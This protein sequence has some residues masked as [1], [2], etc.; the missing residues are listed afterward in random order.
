MYFTKGVWSGNWGVTYE[1]QCAL[2][3]TTVDL[4]CEYDYSLGSIVTWA[5]WSKGQRVSNKLSLVPLSAIPSPPNHFTYLGNYRGNCNLRINNVQPSDQGEFYFSFSTTLGSWREVSSYAALYVKE[6]TSV[7]QPSTAREGDTVRLICRSGCPDP[8]EVAWF[9][10]GQRVWSTVFQARRE[11]A[12]RYLCVTLGKERVWSASVALIVHYAPT[13]VT[14]SANPSGDIDRGST[15]TL[16]CSSKANPPVAQG[17]YRL[18][19]DGEYVSSGQTRV[20]SDVQPRH[21]GRYHCRAWNSLSWRGSDLI[22]SSEIHLNVQYHPV[23]VSVSVNAEPIVEGSSVNLTCSSDAN[24]AADS[25][26]WYKRT[27][28]SSSNSLLHV[29]SGQVLSIPSMESS[30]SGLYVCHVRNSRGEGNSTEVVLAMAAEQRGSQLLPILAGV[31]LFLVALLVAAL[32]LFRKKEKNSAEKNQTDLD[33]RLNGGTSNSEEATA[34]IYSNIHILPPCPDPYNTPATKKNTRRS[35]EAEIIYSTVTIK[36]SVQ[37]KTRHK[38]S[39]SKGREDD[40][41]V[42][43]S[44]VV[45]SS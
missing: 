15:V 45:K 13:D 27:E 20:I 31:G 5:G 4:K 8:T 3:G 22:N 36:P 2:I 21:T 10:D 41:S 11:D 23:N 7:V 44:S 39:W 28:T 17:G 29:G 35:S 32:L 37:N 16:T 34:A 14:L 26:T 30:H 1:N 43:Y 18:Y 19:K 12:G 40:S 25:Y 33:S 6:L 9:K 24:P 38:N 42:I